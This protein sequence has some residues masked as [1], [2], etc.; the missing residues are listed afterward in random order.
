MTQPS[1]NFGPIRRI[2]SVAELSLEIRNLLERQF[3]DVWV[4]GEVSNLRAAGSGHLYFTLKD[5]TAQLRAVCFRNQARYLKFKPQDGLAVIARG[6]LSLYEARG[7]YQLYV[8]FLE[9]AGLGALQLAFEQLK[10]KFAAEGLFDP[11]RKKPLPMLPRSIGVVTSPTGAVIRDILRILR[12]RFRNINVLL[13]PV[14]VQ[15]EG[16]AQE[17]AQGIEYFNRK[18]PV[19]VMI[20][21]R[22]GGSL[23][24][25]W[26]FNEEAV[27]RAIAASNIPVISAVGHETDF[28]I[29]D[30]V[31]DLRAPTPSAA[32]ELVVRHKQ[33]LVT[34]LY[35]RMR[36]LSQVIRLKISEARQ[37]VTE[38]R[39]HQAFQT[40]ATRLAERAQR[41]DEGVSSLE[42]LM[43][44]RL[45]A[46]RQEWLRA[47]AG[48]VRYDFSRHLRLKHAV[49][50][51]RGQ[52]L[53]ND[54]RCFLTERHNRLAQLRSVLEERS[55]RTI[56]E[57]GYSVTRDATGKIIRDAAWVP[58]GAEVSIRLARGELGVVVRESKT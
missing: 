4:T 1:L 20:V 36:H 33:D 50:D 7:E 9:P 31:A 51:E 35:N 56:L 26:A 24:D 8:E 57:R 11:G 52:R 16:A 3:P 41:V 18:A 32:A 17:I 42:R 40:L 19:D 54:F 21:A 34:E 5:E 47:S 55:P 38:L 25:L 46:A 45:H 37:A 22:G 28:T 53:Q 10:Q 12:R 43:H 27:A 23:E 49:L 48:V 6:R 39:L 15:G 2:F 29:A 14:K 58:I 44:S 13:Y 30:F